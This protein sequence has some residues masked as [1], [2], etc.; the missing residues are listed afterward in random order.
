MK[1]ILVVLFL[2]AYTIFVVWLL[3]NFHPK[4]NLIEGKGIYNEQL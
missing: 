1:K 3:F 2:I 4:D